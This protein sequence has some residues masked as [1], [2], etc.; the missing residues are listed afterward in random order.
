MQEAATV[1]IIMFNC[2][3]PSQMGR[4]SEARGCP[5][6]IISDLDDGVLPEGQTS[7][8][9]VVVPSSVLSFVLVVLRPRKAGQFKHINIYREL[10]EV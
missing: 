1:G 9:S 6:Y 2:F 8:R 4:A 10:T 7:Y 5:D 3:G